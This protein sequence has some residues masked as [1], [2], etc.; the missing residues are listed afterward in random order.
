MQA[1]LRTSEWDSARVMYKGRSI[2][3]VYRRSRASPQWMPWVV[4]AP[5]AIMARL[6]IQGLGLYAA[7]GFKRRDYIGQYSHDKVVNEYPTRQAAMAAPETRKLLLRGHDKLITV[8][9][10][11]APGFL[12]L[13]G[14]GGGPPHVERANDPRNTTLSCNA[15]ITDAGWLRVS[16]FR[17][18]AFNLEKSVEDNIKSELRIDYQQEYWDLFDALGKTTEYAIHVD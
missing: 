13:D 16:H 2:T 3:Y 10:Q 6:D 17:V 5:S 7:R 1:D 9:K 12:L 18:P 8:R 4:V 15:F 14:E 11:N